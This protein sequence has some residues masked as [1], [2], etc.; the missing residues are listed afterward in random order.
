VAERYFHALNAPRGKQIVWFGKSGHVP[1]LEEP[2]KYRA[3]LIGKVLT[4]TRR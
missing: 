3:A 2:E 1:H 4:G